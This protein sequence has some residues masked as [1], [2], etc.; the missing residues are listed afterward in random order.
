MRLRIIVRGNKFQVWHFD[1]LLDVA[2]GA[3]L[4]MH[5]PFV[6]SRHATLI[7]IPSSYRS[8]GTCLGYI[9]H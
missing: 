9:M 6:R 8:S 5:Q 3:S 1:G 4:T 7:A 2:F